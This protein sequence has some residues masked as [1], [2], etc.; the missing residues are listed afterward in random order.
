MAASPWPMPEVSTITTS[1][2]AHLVAAITSGKAAL[3]SLP[4][5][6]V[7]K[8]RIKTRWS[9]VFQGAMAFMRMRSPSNAPPLLRREGS[10]EMTAMRKLSS[11]S[12]RMR[13]ISSS[14]SEDL[15][16]PPVPVIPTTG[17]CSVAAWLCNWPRTAS[18]AALLPGAWF[19]S[20]V[21]SCA[22]ERQAA[23]LAPSMALNA[24]GAWTFKS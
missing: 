13:R 1:K 2:P 21:M 24:V 5:S 9:D 8:E 10:M 6:R 18:K 12:K 17:T 14:V 20:A 15:P 16:A 7:A 22:K 4:N 19:S 23:G 11:W 3:I